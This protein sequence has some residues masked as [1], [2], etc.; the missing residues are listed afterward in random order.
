MSSAK[1]EKKKK[2]ETVKSKKAHTLSYRVPLREIC[3]RKVCC[4]CAIHARPYGHG[5]PQWWNKSMSTATR[6]LPIGENS[7]K[8]KNEKKSYTTTTPQQTIS[9]TN[10]LILNLF[11]AAA[12][13]LEMAHTWN[14]LTVTQQW[15]VQTCSTAE[16][17]TSEFVREYIDGIGL[18]D[19]LTYE[20]GVLCCVVCCVSVYLCL[21]SS[22]A[23]V[24]AQF[25]F[26]I[27]NNYYN[28]YTDRTMV[29]GVFCCWYAWMLWSLVF[30]S[31]GDGIGWCMKCFQSPFNDAQLLLE[32]N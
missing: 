31:W 3:N 15:L 8:K 10:T 16:S 6:L 11:A 4:K 23:T 27:L 26:N 18:F 2:K 19:H 1:R 14:I 21:E 17:Q 32:L 20:W 29:T 12:A 22:S 7:K 24:L 25:H 5:A 30:S 28:I 9:K 13:A